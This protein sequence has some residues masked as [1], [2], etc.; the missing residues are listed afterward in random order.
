[1]SVQ[2]VL[3]RTAGRRI[4]QSEARAAGIALPEKPIAFDLR[5]IGATCHQPID[6]LLGADFFQGRIVQIDYQAMR[7]RILGHAAPDEAGVEVECRL[8]ALS[9]LHHLI[10]RVGHTYR[11]YL[12]TLGRRLITTCYKLHQWIILPNLQPATV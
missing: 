2:G 11:Y 10:K 12:T 3:S 9:R 1:M 6:G 7:M 5:T 4:A 8:P